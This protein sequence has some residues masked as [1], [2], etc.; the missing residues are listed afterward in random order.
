MHQNC[1]KLPDIHPNFMWI[2]NVPTSSD[3]DEMSVIPNHPLCRGCTHID[4]DVVIRCA[5]D[6]HAF[7]QVEGGQ[8]GLR[9]A[10]TD[11][12]VQMHKIRRRDY[13][14]NTDKNGEQDSLDLPGASHSDLSSA[15]SRPPLNRV[16]ILD[17]TAQIE[18]VRALPIYLSTVT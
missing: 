8:L 12:S 16:P 17:H 13:C 5:T 18:G 7:V 10:A 14:P 15:S 4:E 2:T 3:G 1:G 11:R 6:S 9:D